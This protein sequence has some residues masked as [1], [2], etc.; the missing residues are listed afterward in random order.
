MKDLKIF[1]YH[2]RA[3][4]LS[5]KSSWLAY[6]NNGSFLSNK[7]ISFELLNGNDSNLNS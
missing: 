3:E 6:M 2:L 7:Q 4:T 5:I 1:S